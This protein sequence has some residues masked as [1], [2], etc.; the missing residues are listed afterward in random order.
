[1]EYLNKTNHI[2]LVS[3]HDIELT[4]L[5]KSGYELHYFQET[6][7]DES[8][9]FDYILKQGALKKRNAINIIE[10]AGYPDQVLADAR[11]L[12]ANFEKEQTE[13]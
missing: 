7:V 12:A 4:L 5:L 9:S 2:V 3:T 10:L 8:L 1:M 13:N 6:I 11:S